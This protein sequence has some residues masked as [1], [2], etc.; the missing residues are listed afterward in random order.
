MVEESG[1]LEGVGRPFLYAITE[2]FMHHFGLT[3][4]NELPALQ[5]EE[6]DLLAAAAEHPP[7]PAP[8]HHPVAGAQPG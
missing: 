4:M 3:H 2:Q 8:P 5:P 7:A 1:R 6:S